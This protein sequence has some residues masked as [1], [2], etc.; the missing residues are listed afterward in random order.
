MGMWY[1]RCLLSMPVLVPMLTTHCT[2]GGHTYRSV[3]RNLIAPS[4]I[5]YDGSNYFRSDRNYMTEI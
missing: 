5:H 4:L 2:I 1:A 3:V